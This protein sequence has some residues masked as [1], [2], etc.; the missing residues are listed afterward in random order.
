MLAQGC[1][2]LASRKDAM[3]E[4]SGDGLGQMPR[5]LECFLERA[6]YRGALTDDE[7]VVGVRPGIG[8]RLGY[9]ST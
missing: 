6:A 4:R 9:G 8:M 2:E 1:A 7:G 5:V 3:R